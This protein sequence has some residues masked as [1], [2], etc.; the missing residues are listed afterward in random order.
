MRMTK[1]E[2][3]DPVTLEVGSGSC[4]IEISGTTPNYQVLATAEIPALF[5][6]NKKVTSKLQADVS[7]VSGVTTVTSLKEIY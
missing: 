7:I 6:S 5:Y 3:T 1:E 4:I 2:F